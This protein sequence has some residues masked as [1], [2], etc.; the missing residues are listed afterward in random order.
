[1]KIGYFVPKSASTAPLLAQNHLRFPKYQSNHSFQFQN[2]AASS[3]ALLAPRSL[4]SMS[5][6]HFPRHSYF[7]PFSREQS[8]EDRAKSVKTGFVHKHR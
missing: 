1:M 7:Q 6:L 5:S 8:M 2:F 4:L 3:I